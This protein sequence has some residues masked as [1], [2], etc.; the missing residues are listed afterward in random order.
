MIDVRPES[1]PARD[2]RRLFEMQRDAYLAQPYPSPGERRD[3]LQRL[4]A[5]IEVHEQ[6]IVAAIA[7]D[8]GTRPAQET[9]LAELFMIA[10]GI[11]HARRNLGPWMAQQRVPTP[12][13][14][15][16]E[17]AGYFVRRSAR[18]LH[19]SHGKLSGPLA[20]FRSLAALAAETGS[21]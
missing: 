9:R 6:D 4:A 8:F 17:G 1:N 21:C 16:R 12:L 3:R 2:I 10:A 14:C 18:R 19:Q 5:L 15:G 11:R 20:L 7:A 13:I